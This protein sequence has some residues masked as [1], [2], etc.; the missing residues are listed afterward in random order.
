MRDYALRNI[1]SIRRAL[2]VRHGAAAL[3]LA[4]V[5][6]SV[7]P[8]VEAAVFVGVTITTAP[9]VLPVYVQPAIPAPGYIWTPGYWAW[10]DDGYFWVPG[11]WILPPYVGA[12]WTPGYW[13]WSSGVYIFHAGYWGRHV[14]FY[15]GINYGFGYTGVGYGGGYWGHGGFYYNRTVNQINNVHITNV[16]NKT[17]I[18]N[19]TVNRVSYNGGNGGVSA[20]PSSQEMA[21]AHEQH[22]AP[23]AAQM[24][25]RQLASQNQSLRASFNHGAPPIAA[26]AHPG[27]FAGHDV[28]AA[29]GAPQANA[30]HAMAMQNHAATAPNRLNALPSAGFAH[31]ANGQRPGMPNNGAN[32]FNT[33]AHAMQAAHAGQPQMS[34]HARPQ[35]FGEARPPAMIHQGEMRPG[36]APHGAPQ[37]HPNRPS[38]G[39]P[40]ERHER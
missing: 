20:R 12:L 16:Y 18:N 34:S 8:K 37:P 27:V 23:M 19:V 4:I 9:P 10:G 40:H 7:A 22:T 33:Q 21:Y 29:H 5:G 35:A 15:G 14:G 25:Q 26:T 32:R 11:T 13:G 1:R 28:V 3:A 30:A 6:V 36:G 24:Q 2:L 17:V 39:Q 31:P 38:E